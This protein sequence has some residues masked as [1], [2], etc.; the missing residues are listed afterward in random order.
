VPSAFVIIKAFDAQYVAYEVFYWLGVNK[1]N[2]GIIA[3]T[4]DVKM[5]C[6]RALR[7]EGITFSTDVSSALTVE[8]APKLEVEILHSNANP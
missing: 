4:N 7:D 1:G 6:W 5:S 8:N 3:V 2:R